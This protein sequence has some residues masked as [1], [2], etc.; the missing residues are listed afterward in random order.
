MVFHFS[1]LTLFPHEV[2]FASVSSV[3]EGII[4]KECVMRS[5]SIGPPKANQTMTDG[6]LERSQGQHVATTR[7]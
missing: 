5:K 6:H 7:T 1:S 2:T 4:R 3:S